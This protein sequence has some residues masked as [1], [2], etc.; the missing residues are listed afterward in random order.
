MN[1]ITHP[2][3]YK[4]STKGAD[5][6]WTIGVEYDPKAS[7]ATIVT[8]WGQIGGSIQ[9]TRDLIK[10]GKNV[11][12]KNETTAEQQAKFEAEA[13]WVKQL[14]KGYVQTLE[15]AQAGEV[16]AIIEGGISPMLAHRF[17][18]QGHKIV[19]PAFA[20]PKLDGHRC[21]AVIKDGKATLW[22]R[23][24]KPITGLP[25]IIA[26]LEKWAEF[27]GIVELTLDGELYNHAYKD[28][29]EDLTS[30]IRNP[31]PKL[32]H[33]AVQ[34]HIYDV[35]A[36]KLEQHHRVEELRC[37]FA[38]NRFKDTLVFVE[39]ITAADEDELM[40]AFERFQ[41]QGYEGLMVRNAAGQYVGTR[42]ADLQKVKEAVDAEFMVVGVEEGR[43]KLAGHAIFV[44]VTSEMDVV[45][46]KKTYHIPA[47]KEFRAKMKG[48]TAK[49]K[50]YFEN[51]KLA[52]GRMMTVEFRGVTNKTK[53][54]RFP[55]ALRFF[56]GI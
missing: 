14:K 54:P 35:A 7:G 34:Y 39:T 30:F 56:E 29:F 17:D 18:E 46:N 44:C 5:Q 51:P 2:T 53:V 10:S 21:I 36:E 24:R 45:I 9:E 50:Q 15:A 6:E 48:E 11:G 43:G 19:Y 28:N 49:L 23:T 47:G 40:L 55:V 31:E 25:H 3:L 22:S 52:I 4:K 38:R 41:L 8:R 26:T 42:S 13:K 33:E 16:D 20:Q 12:K 1:F 27:E 37:F 32:G